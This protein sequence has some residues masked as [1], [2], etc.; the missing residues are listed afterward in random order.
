MS[1]HKLGALYNPAYVAT[2]IAIG[3]AWFGSSQIGW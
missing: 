3:L 1:V 2:Y